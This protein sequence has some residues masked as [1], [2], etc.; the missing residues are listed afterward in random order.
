VKELKYLNSY[1]LKYKWLLLFGILF[2]IA[3]NVFKVISPRILGF[4]I[5]MVAENISFYKSFASFELQ[6]ALQAS[7]RQKLLI[8]CLIYFLA[9]ILSGLFTF[10]MRQTIIVM[11]RYIEFDLKNEIYTHYQALDLAFYKRNNT[12][13]LM[14]RIT[15]DVSRVRMYLGPALMYSINV[16]FLFGFVIYTMLKINAQLT[17]WVLLPMP[18]L[19]LSI[20]YVNGLIN[21]TSEKIQEQL[22]NLTSH[23]QEYYSG[24]RVLKSF[25]QEKL[26][27]R[28]YEKESELYKEKSL[29]LARI[30]A[31]FFPVMV[32]LIGFSNII[33]IFV[34]GRQVIQGLITPGNLLEFV[35]YVNMLSWPITSIGW[36]ASLIQRAAASQKRINAFLKTQPQIT[37][38]NTEKFNINGSIEFK[39]VSFTYP[40]TGIEALK[41]VSFTINKGEKWALI[42]K[43]GSGK[44]TIA[45]LIFRL[46]DPTS[47]EIYIDGKNIKELNLNDL[48]SQIGFVPQ[49]VFL[50]S[51]TIQNNIRFSDINLTQEK[52]EAAAKN[53]S[54]HNEINQFPRQYET[55]VGERGVT[56]SGGQKQRISIARALIK[57]PEI[58]IFDDALSAVDANT[59]KT[60]LTNLRKDIEGKTVIIITHRIF[61]LLEFDGI[62]VLEGGEI[63]ERGSHNHLMKLNGHYAEIYNMQQV[64]EID[65]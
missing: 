33:V 49:D 57:K 60:I 61:S 34:G 46:Y 21:K 37:N 12:G 4:A 23:A 55:F 18:I 38:V 22:S 9:A 13:D 52:V 48:R 5:D 17:F 30:E 25:V 56:L 29:D 10:F 3:S 14:N 41:N 50:F 11:S 63:Q 51:D 16:L 39:N 53:A 45:E 65:A 62:I 15:E 24:I 44:S 7:F 6:N 36:A 31:L 47:G 42:G 64:E 43:T 54:I 19:A 32:F 2:V 58:L 28:F 27:L 1:F 59:E 40:D 20:F 26:A 35:M 8:F